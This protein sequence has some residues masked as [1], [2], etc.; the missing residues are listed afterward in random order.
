MTNK[1]GEPIWYELMA[2][3]LDRAKS[4]Y[5]AVVGWTIAPPSQPME[6]AENYRFLTRHDGGMT[7]GAM[8]LSE[9]MREGGAK[10]MWAVYFAVAD[11]DTSVGKLK[12][13]GGSVLIEPFDIPEVG[14]IAFVADPQGIPFYVMRGAS[15]GTSEVYTTGSGA[16][17]QTGWNE[18]LTSDLDAALAF[19]GE[20]LGFA[21][22]EKM[23]MG[24]EMG[25]YCFLDLGELRLGAAMKTMEQGPVTYSKPP[26]R[27]RKCMDLIQCSVRLFPVC[28]HSMQSGKG[29]R[30][31]QGHRQGLDRL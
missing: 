20:L 15:D 3:D 28:Q 7:G 2:G 1:A 26:L 5:E 30:D 14:R 19:Y 23:E 16:F 18:L 24:P 27:A 13:L 11:V 25:P 21:V 8:Q 22:N 12:E 29:H 31:R 6:G 10:P 17:G 4:F 9:A